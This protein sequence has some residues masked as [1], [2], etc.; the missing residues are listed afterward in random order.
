MLIIKYRWIFFSLSLMLVAAAVT[1]LT[2]F[3]LNRGIDFTGGTI[4]EVEYLGERPSA[5]E[6]RGLANSLGLGN[7]TAQ[8]SGERGAIFRFRHLS[9]AEHV[10][11]LESLG[12]S[13]RVVER[14]FSSIGP[15]IGAELTRRGLWSIGLVVLLILVYIA[16]AFRQVSRSESGAVRS[17]QY[18]LVAIVT[19]AHDTL[20]PIGVFV[21]LGQYFNMEADLLFIT[22]VLTN[23]GLSINDRMVIF[24]RIRENVGRRTGG[25]FA[26]VVGRSLDETL[27][28]SFNTSL[29]VLFVLLALFFFGASATRDFT[30]MLT[31]GMAVATYSSIC[32]AAPLL[33][34]WHQWSRRV[35]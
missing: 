11:L 32:L 18:G 15:T 16:L 30:L 21:V 14:R 29:T 22:A 4:V 28:R 2:Y 31:L 20:I 8:L 25:D 17:W 12:G 24:D 13:K 27:T 19:L 5:E 7:A 33:V 3:G 9:E 26:M 34:S 23:L 6:I 10:Q 1:A 35:K